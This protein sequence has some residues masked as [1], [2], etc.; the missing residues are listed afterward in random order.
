MYKVLTVHIFPDYNIGGGAINVEMAIEEAVKFAKIQG[1]QIVSITH[2]PKW[3]VVIMVYK[4]G[5]RSSR[6]RRTRWG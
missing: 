6:N 3:D 2:D 1:A 4:G 5:A